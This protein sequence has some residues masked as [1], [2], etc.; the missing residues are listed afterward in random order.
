M[1]AGFGGLRA[2]RKCW[3]TLRR[4]RHQ[5]GRDVNRVEFIFKTVNGIASKKHDSITE[6][7]LLQAVLSE[8]DVVKGERRTKSASAGS[9]R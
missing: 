2:Y 5:G 6:Y 4:H 3:W 7:M 1:L 9:G 8:I